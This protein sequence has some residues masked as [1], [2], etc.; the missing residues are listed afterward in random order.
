[1]AGFDNPSAKV[2]RS[3]QQVLS[4]H[5]CE[6]L[7]VR[8]VANQ[9]LA[10]Q[11]IAE[12]NGATGASLRETVYLDGLPLSAIDVAASPK[13]LYAVHVDH[14]HRP[15]LLTDAAKATVWSASYEPFGKVRTLTG[16][17]TQNLG[18][19]GQWFQLET[20]LAYNWHRH[21]DPTTGRYTTADPL[22]FVDGP[23]VFAYVGSSPQTK[24]D[25]TGLA[26]LRVSVGS[27]FVCATDS[28][29]LRVS[30]ELLWLDGTVKIDINN[31][32]GFYDL[33]YGNKAIVNFGSRKPAP[34]LSSDGPAI[35]GSTMNANDN[36][37]R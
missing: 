28:N 31:N 12:A 36:R 29:I 33:G 1:L 24:V 3:I 4:R 8:V 37:R 20:G 23:S 6:R 21:Y 10:G 30:G 26:V 17:V 32:L 9:N 19:P 18:L 7:R 14:L 16:T 11:I 15:I 2:W 34:A 35:Q 22:G 27:G 25:P 5:W 13:K